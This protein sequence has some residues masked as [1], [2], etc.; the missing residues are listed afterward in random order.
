MNDKFTKL[1][2]IGILLCLIVIGN[3]SMNNQSATPNSNI[4]INAG[5][6]V[7]QLAPNRIAVIDNRNNSGMRGTILIFD[8][9]SND[10][11]F[12]YIGSMNY[13]DYFSN[14]YKYGITTN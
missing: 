2:L 12:N 1:I 9:D 5:E 11:K 10:K 8:Y 4:N 13:A 3:N 6:Q 14:P 7:I